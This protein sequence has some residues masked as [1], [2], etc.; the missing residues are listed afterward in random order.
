[1]L[2]KSKR[3][4]ELCRQMK[5]ERCGEDGWGQWTRNKIWRGGW[6]LGW[7]G[8]ISLSCFPFS[9]PAL[10]IS[11]SPSTP[12]LSQLLRV[13]GGR[14][15]QSSRW[16]SL[17]PCSA[18]EGRGTTSRSMGLFWQVQQQWMGIITVSLQRELAE[19]KAVFN[20][21]KSPCNY[22]KA[23]GERGRDRE[24]ERRWNESWW[25][26]RRTSFQVLHLERPVVERAL[27]FSSVKKFT[28]PSCSPLIPLSGS[29]MTWNVNMLTLVTFET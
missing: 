7:D 12:P 11:L 15:S 13:V 9:S 29:H 23:R 26:A 27:G 1:M 25:E 21:Q 20:V 19:M 17:E 4:G 6:Y 28:A 8:N 5:K 18:L 10:C 16:P 3:A 2:W 22:L 24:R 14:P